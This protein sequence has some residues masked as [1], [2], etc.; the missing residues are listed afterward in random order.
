MCEFKNHKI[1]FPVKAKFCALIF[2]KGG[3][4]DTP[5]FFTSNYE[6][7]LDDIIRVMWP[8]Q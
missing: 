6:T 1:L 2:E 3:S 5:W 4:F 8:A 7:A